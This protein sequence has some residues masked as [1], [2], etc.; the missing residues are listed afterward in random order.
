MK[1][2]H[3]HPLIGDEFEPPPPRPNFR[4]GEI[5]IVQREDGSLRAG[6]WL[7]LGLR[8]YPVDSRGDGID[9][10]VAAGRPS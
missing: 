9:G 3:F 6:Y 4:N 2:R 8:G 5:V 7:Y 1:P 10:A